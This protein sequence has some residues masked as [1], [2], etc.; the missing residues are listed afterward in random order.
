[1]RRIF[2]VT[3]MIH[4]WFNWSTKGTFTDN[5]HRRLSEWLRPFDTGLATKYLN[6]LSLISFSTD[7]GYPPLCS[8]NY[9][10]AN[11]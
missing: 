3:Q 10:V 7:N 11:G 5:T 8:L 1:M 6:S 4:S 2:P 9:D